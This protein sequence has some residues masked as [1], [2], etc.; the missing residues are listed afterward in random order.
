MGIYEN[1]RRATQ[2][3]LTDTFWKIYQ[4]RPISKITVKEITEQC[5]VG[6]G[7]FYNHFQDVYAILDG[8]EQEL[9]VSLNALCEQVR[10]QALG[11]TDFN[12]IL[13]DCYSDSKTREYV[14]LLVLEHRDPFFAQ[15]YTNTLKKLLFEVC[16]EDEAEACTPKEKLILNGAISAF[17][18]LLLDC[19]CTAIDIDISEINEFMMGIMQNGVYV[20]LTNRFG[21]HA[22]KNPFSMS[23]TRG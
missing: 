14:Q 17:V 3:K 15:D 1:A 7:T 16:V 2:Q 6:R 21:I 11:L 10:G 23:L 19:I 13:Y 18:N 20:T 9:S 4:T 5:G 22:L 12:R 8:I